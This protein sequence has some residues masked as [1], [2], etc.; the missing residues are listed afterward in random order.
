MIKSLS[1]ETLE[2]GTTSIDKIVTVCAILVNLSDG[3][4]YNE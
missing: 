1:D 4:V 2:N 3:I